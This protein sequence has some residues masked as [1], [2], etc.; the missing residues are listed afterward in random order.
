MSDPED[1]N[2]KPEDW[3]ESSAEELMQYAMNSVLDGREPKTTEDWSK[4]VNYI[5]FNVETGKEAVVMAIMKALYSIPLTAEQI[6]A[7]IQ[8]QIKEKERLRGKAE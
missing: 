4:I 6:V 5:A 2:L 7:I 3:R 1:T 8:F